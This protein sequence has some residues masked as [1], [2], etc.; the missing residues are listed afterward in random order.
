MSIKKGG[1]AWARDEVDPGVNDRENSFG[2]MEGSCKSG[3]C[4][5]QNYEMNRSAA[6][7]IRKLRL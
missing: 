1:A 3:I 7:E 4:W 6:A 2:I 5:M